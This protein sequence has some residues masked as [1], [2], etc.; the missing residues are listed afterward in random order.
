MLNQFKTKA[1]VIEFLNSI[2]WISAHS[3]GFFATT[4]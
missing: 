2:D 3:D 1:K 4:S